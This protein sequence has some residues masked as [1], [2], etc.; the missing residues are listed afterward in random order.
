[1]FVYLGFKLEGNNLTPVTLT[2]RSTLLHHLSPAPSS[3]GLKVVWGTDRMADTFTMFYF[4]MDHN[5]FPLT[6]K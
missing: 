3:S 1:M 4:C 6:A 5:T 2:V